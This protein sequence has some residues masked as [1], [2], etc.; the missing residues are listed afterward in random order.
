MTYFSDIITRSSLT[1]QL[2]RINCSVAKIDRWIDSVRDEARGRTSERM[3]GCDQ[4]RDRPGSI[5]PA[6][7][8]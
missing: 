3:G 1:K 4:R 5:V 2:M 6:S 8:C 7:L